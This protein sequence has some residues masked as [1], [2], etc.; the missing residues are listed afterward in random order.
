MCV[1]WCHRLGLLYFNHFD[2]DRRECR[3]AGVEG[4]DCAG[5]RHCRGSI[6]G[7]TGAAHPWGGCCHYNIERATGPQRVTAATVRLL[8]PGANELPGAVLDGF[9][10]PYRIDEAGEVWFD[11]AGAPGLPLVYGLG[12]EMYGL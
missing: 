5:C 11:P 8:Y 9:D 2:C 1:T 6:C 3:F 12:T 7:L 4:E 10:L